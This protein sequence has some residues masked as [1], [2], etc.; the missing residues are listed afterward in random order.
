MMLIPT[1]VHTDSAFPLLWG[2][3]EMTD[4]S[5]TLW[6]E[7]CKVSG[8]LLQDFCNVQSINSVTFAIWSWSLPKPLITKVVSMLNHMTCYCFSC[9]D[10]LL[11]F[12]E[13]SHGHHMCL[14]Y[15]TTYTLLAKRLL[16]EAIAK[17]GADGGYE[18]H[19]VN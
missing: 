11:L 7:L 10:V 15:F 14:Y 18:I 3:D 8:C 17:R 4:C 2:A 19:L 13:G 9:F 5:Q 6:Q 16:R 1:A 12:F